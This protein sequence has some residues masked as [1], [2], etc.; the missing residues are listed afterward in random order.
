MSVT[1][2]KVEHPVTVKVT[3]CE[4]GGY[5]WVVEDLRLVGQADT[6]EDLHAM[7]KEDVSTLLKWLANRYDFQSE[8]R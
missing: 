6:M 4:G 8:M 1:I 2:Q 5:A 3:D 7:V